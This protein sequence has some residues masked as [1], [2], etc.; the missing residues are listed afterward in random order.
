M[1]IF[2]TETVEETLKSLDSNPDGLSKK[3][4]SERL[5]ESG[6]NE[7][8]PTE[9]IRPALIFL[10][11]FN[12]AFIY[13]LFGAALLSF[14]LDHIVDVYVI[15]AVI[16][17]NA[18]IGFFEELRAE[19]AIEQ[20][21]KILVLF[22][23]VYRGGELLRIPASE[24]VPGDILFLEE[25]DK[26]SADARL[27]DVKNLR[28]S[29]A[30]LTGESFPVDKTTNELE[31]S[32]S[33][34]DQKNMVWMGT[35][36]VGG[37][38]KAVVTAT[39]AGTAIGQV[40]ESITKVKRPKSHFEK[41]T[42]ELAFQMG[43]IA[44]AG[45]AITFFIGFFIRGLELSEIFIFS[46]ALLVSVIPEGLP[47]VMA[48]VLAIGAY[49][50]ARKK[51]IIKHLPA[52][53]TIGVAT[54][55]ATDKTGTITQNSMM[56]EKIIMA[57]GD[58]ITVSGSGWKPSGSFFRDNESI[59]PLRH[60]DLSRLLH[61]AAVCNKSKVFKTDNHFEIIGDPTEAALAV[62]AEKAGLR[63]NIVL[64]EEQVLDELPFDQERKYRAVLT[65]HRR[66]TICV[67]GAFENILTL[68]S[69]ALRG[70]K[71]VILTN[72][73]RQQILYSAENL[74]AEG[75]RVLA[76]GFREVPARTEK[77]S[78]TLV[79]QLTFVGV[80][81][82]IDPP[83][84]EVKDA[85]TRAKQAGLRVIMKTGDHKKTAVAIA[86]EIGLVDPDVK[87][88]KVVLT[89]DDLTN[90]L[91]LGEEGFEEA[92]RTVP[93]FARVSP[94]MKLKIV[95]TLQKQGETVAMTGD[96]VNDAPALKKADIGIAMGVIGTDVARE[97]S[98]IVLADDN[99]ASIVDAI[100]EGRIVFTNV[101]Q[102][103]FYLI[104]TNIAEGI[105]V[106]GTL[107]LFLPLPLLPIHLLWLNLVTDGIPT[108]GLAMERGHHHE[109][110]EKPR[111]AKEKILS[112][113]VVPYI[114]LM[115][116]LM[117]VGTIV[118][119]FLYLPQ[120]LEKARTVA[121]TVMAFFQLFNVLNMRSLRNSVFK[122]GFFT[123]K[124]IN[125]A[126]LAA[127]AVQVAVIHIPFLQKAF[128][129]EPLNLGEW[130]MI[131]ALTSSVFWFGELYKFLRKQ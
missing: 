27:I 89:E 67:V 61:I 59:H 120:G 12:S 41:K 43:I 13:I 97:T 2:H 62:L 69:H 74:A 36:V 28:T 19:N 82:M 103:S 88:E 117:V 58:E 129:F 6:F 26:V 50:M 114:L 3:E 4:A 44:V 90:L 72:R 20:L 37:E 15:L 65:K 110:S 63:K 94:K 79:K 45:A 73:E 124:F 31:Q 121:F 47:A 101:R 83:R 75:L 16:F 64:E 34:A 42:K 127:I 46:V 18:L 80:V 39:G 122:I 48:I 95:E 104:T 131:I 14:F 123:N 66:K 33:L 52:V 91:K 115:A 8:P 107:L 92:V 51:A 57:G 102:T 17:F 1:N 23:K 98:E 38:A 116:G 9:K 85:I 60:G 125:L 56:V 21:K 81:G 119:F 109:L 40:A 96:G 35:V 68:S 70:G 10:K 25:G 112:K 87:L 53:E 54:V 128:R 77:I 30:S 78:P 71:K 108:I 5:L 49:R 55:I 126:L 99:F 22:A 130:L 29:E 86:R 11:Q 76:L 111:S 106:I 7:L 118:I 84:P 93:I 105:T 32:T 100:E 24:V 113:E